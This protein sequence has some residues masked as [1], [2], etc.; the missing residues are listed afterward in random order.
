MLPMQDSSAAQRV[1]VY[2][3]N[4]EGLWDDKGTGHISV[5]YLEVGS[6]PSYVLEQRGVGGCTAVWSAMGGA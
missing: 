4:A 6:A 2:R 1:K 3:L 5:E